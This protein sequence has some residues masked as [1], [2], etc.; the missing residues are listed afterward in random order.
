MPTKP[1]NVLEESVEVE[2]PSGTDVADNTKEVA[3][4][5]D[6]ADKAKKHSTNV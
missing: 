1:M 2:S 3:P 4:A 5:I 6:V